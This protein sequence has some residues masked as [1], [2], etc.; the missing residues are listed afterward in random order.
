MAPIHAAHPLD[1]RVQSQVEQ[2]PGVVVD[3]AVSCSYCHTLICKGPIIRTIVS[4]VVASLTQDGDLVSTAHQAKVASH[5]L[6]SLVCEVL[7]RR[8]LGSL[9]TCAF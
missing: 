8:S 2:V 6:P 1:L 7:S 3:I 9:V 4:F 5:T